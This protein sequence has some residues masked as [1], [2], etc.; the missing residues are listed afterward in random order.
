MAQSVERIHGKDE[1]AGPIPARSSN[2][3]PHHFGVGFL[4][5]SFYKGKK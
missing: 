1:V 3:T 4:N 2:K 5:A